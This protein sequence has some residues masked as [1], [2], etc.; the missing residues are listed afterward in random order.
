MQGTALVI[1][2]SVA[3]VL[4]YRRGGWE[5]A[6]HRISDGT[7]VLAVAAYFVWALLQQALF[8]LYLLGRLLTLLPRAVAK[9]CPRTF[10]SGRVEFR[11]CGRGNSCFGT[12]NASA[13]HSEIA[14]R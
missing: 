2:L 9:N 5:G 11:R 1:L 10:N 13:I 3:V 14:G 6:L 4:G 8:Q 12:V 7:I